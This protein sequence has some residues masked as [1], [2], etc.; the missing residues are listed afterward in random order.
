VDIFSFVLDEGASVGTKA[1]GWLNKYA[2]G[3]DY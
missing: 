1:V 3:V 2:P